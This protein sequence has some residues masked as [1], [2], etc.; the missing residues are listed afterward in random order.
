MRTRLFTVIPAIP[1]PL[2]R[3]RELAY[4]LWW[5]WNPD[6]VELFRRIDIELWEETWHNP[7]RLLSEVPQDRLEQLAGDRAFL[8]NMDRVLD[9]FYIYSAAR[10][11]YSENLTDRI[12]GKIAYFSAEFG[13]HECLPVYSG[14]LG[15]LAGDHLKSASDLGL[16]LVGVGLFYRQ[17]YFHQYLTNDGWQFEDYPDLDFLHLPITLARNGGGEPIQVHVDIGDHSVALQI[18]KVQVG[19]VPLYLLDSY[20]P[21]NRVEDRGITGRLY[22]GDH[23]TRIRQEIVLG[24]GGIRALAALGIDPLVCHMNEGH[25]AFLALERIRQ[26]VCEK[27][28][29]VAEAQEVVAAGNA[30]TTHTPVPAGIDVFSPQLVESY[31]GRYANEMQMSM[32]AILGLGRKNP[33]DAKEPFCMAILALRLAR[34]GNGVS[35]LHG[36]VSRSM[37]Q[38]VWPEIPEVEVPIRSVTNGI[39]VRSWLA[40]EMAHLFE[41]Y[42]GPRWADDPVDQKIWERVKDIPDAELWRSHERLR[43]RFVVAAR[44][45]VRRQ[46]KRRGA[47]PSEIEAADEILDPEA[48]TIGF[49]RRFAPYKRASL[50]LQDKAR[51]LKII[52][53]HDRPV[54]F[55]LAGKA[56]PR[57]N[58]G[59]ELIKEVIQ[60]AKL[61]EVRG[62]VVFI[63]DYDMGVARFLVQG[64]DVWLNNPTKLHEASGTSGMKVPPNGGINMSV[65]DGWWPEAYDGTNG[66]AIGDDRM[67]DND[68]YQDYVESNAIYD[69][70]EKEVVPMFYGRGNDGLPRKWIAKM[71][72]SMRTISPV[73]NTNRMVKDYVEKLYVHSAGQAKRLISNDFAIARELTRW[74]SAM[75]DYWSDLRIQS[76][77]A[78]DIQE[79]P[80]GQEMT[81]KAQIHLGQVMVEDVAVELFHGRVNGENQISDGRALEMTCEGEGGGGNYEYVGRIPCTESGQHG[82]A[83]RILPRH[84]DMQSRHELG[85]IRWG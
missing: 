39:H 72:A 40:Y 2:I 52:T 50:F 76:V 81:V 51:L 77:E 3:L 1:E 35:K 37:W 20:L 70:L 78:S 34:Q 67:Y 21:E 23:E 12:Q 6:A 82:Y 69:L 47:P 14:G 26:N 17:G 38:G 57:D 9:A 44:R 31:L 83:V 68:A 7:V 10:T 46:L 64:V 36:S 84:P 22:G 55:V 15:I 25:S 65:L 18:W 30:F 63:E 56:H 54:Q 33:S 16:P 80:V 32:E 62:R 45:A 49:A 29:S 28:L 27:K 42:L 11:W 74:K 75:V 73:F 79:L 43:E 24:I 48:L 4:N 66:W 8:A 5:T 13:L 53:N 61:P 41:R 71:K 19:R 59:K 58:P 60:F 85:L